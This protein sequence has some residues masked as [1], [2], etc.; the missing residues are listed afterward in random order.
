MERPRIF[1][2]PGGLFFFQAK[3][4][5][6]TLPSIY[7]MGCLFSKPLF[8]SCPILMKKLV[9]SLKLEVLMNILQQ[10]TMGDFLNWEFSEEYLKLHIQIVQPLILL[11]VYIDLAFP[12]KICS[13]R[14]HKIIIPWLKKTQL[15]LICSIRN[16]K[17]NIICL[18][19]GKTSSRSLLVACWNIALNFVWGQRSTRKYTVT[20]VL[21]HVMIHL[22][23]FGHLWKQGITWAVLSRINKY[24][25]EW[26]RT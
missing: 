8:L 16:D 5:K 21:K 2:S 11:I 24:T 25:T 10:L 13:C 23:L 14:K 26:G 4:S 9:L 12:G 7:F 17:Q 20:V 18:T 6:G 15:G 22:D 19:K 1:K 3:Q